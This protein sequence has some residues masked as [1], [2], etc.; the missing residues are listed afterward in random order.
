[1]DNLILFCQVVGSLS[2]RTILSKQEIRIGM[3]S[4]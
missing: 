1:M 3:I 2:H 4:K